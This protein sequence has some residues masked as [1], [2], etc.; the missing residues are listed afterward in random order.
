MGHISKFFTWADLLLNPS[1]LNVGFDPAQLGRTPC[2]I[3]DLKPNNNQIYLHSLFSV[4][5]AQTV[6]LYHF[7]S[8][9]SMV[10]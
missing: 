9:I 8:W 1:D 2:H 4:Q 10:I 3:W 7:P 6:L 5:S